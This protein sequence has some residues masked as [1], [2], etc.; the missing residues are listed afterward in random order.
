MALR[1][2]GSD[3]VQAALE[4]RL[5]ASFKDKMRMEKQE[6]ERKAI[7]KWKKLHERSKS[8]QRQQETNKDGRSMD[9][10]DSDQDHDHKG[11]EVASEKEPKDETKNWA[12]ISEAANLLD[13][14]KDIMDELTILKALISQQKH[15]WEDLVPKG[16]EQDD[17]RGPNYTLRE[18]EEM[19]KMAD[20]VQRSVMSSRMSSQVTHR[21]HLI[22]YMRYLT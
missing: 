4:K 11:Q 15:V 16:S 5:F 9:P 21:L 3:V 18:I 20:T 12:S 8:R 1:V 10:Y 7:G 22:R 13:E 17:A 19:I 14:V 6:T 2:P